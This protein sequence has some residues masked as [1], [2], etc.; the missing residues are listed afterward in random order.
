LP[1]LLLPHAERVE[2]VLE[3]PREGVLEEQDVH[4]E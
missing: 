2:I 3:E 1:A 4:G